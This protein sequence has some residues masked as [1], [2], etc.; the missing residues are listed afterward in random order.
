MTRLRALVFL[1][2]A[3]FAFAG[4]AAAQ[5]AKTVVADAMQAMGMTPAFTSV[6][7]AGS[8][9]F[10]NFLQSNRLS[11]GLAFTSIRDYQRTIDFTR[12]ISRASGIGQPP[13]APN[14]VPPGAF[15]E[16]ITPQSPGNKQLEIWTTPWGFLLGAAKGAAKLKTERIQPPGAAEKLP[17]VYRSVTWTTPF[18]APSGKPYTIIG[19]IGPTNLVEKVETWM[20]QPLM[21]DLEVMFSYTGY[22]DANGLKVPTKISQKNI[23]MEVFAANPATAAANPPELERLLTEGVKPKPPAPVLPQVTSIKLAEGVY[24]LTGGYDALA[25]ELKDQAVIIGGGGDETRALALLAETKRLFPGKAVKAAVSLHGHF[26]HAMVLPTFVSEGLTIYCDDANQYFLEQSLL[27]PRTLLTDALAK[28]KKKP[29]I[30]GIQDKLVLGDATHSVELYHLKQVPH[31]DGMLA[32][33]LPAEKLLF[34]SDV[35]LPEAGQAPSPSLL[36]V[37]QNIDQLALDFD[38]LMTNGPV[39]IDPISKTELFARVQRGR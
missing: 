34:V 25:V 36:A 33:W 15:D 8:A 26:D 28:T 24:R 39:S 35:D 22:A 23:G 14:G 2:V 1:A 32:A 7:F 5:D 38:T 12:G 29:K 6:T 21:G 37:L 19:Y 30:L 10:G 16:L 13:G 18:T 20:D 3:Q 27:Q 4:A 11:F 17:T 9:A 31:A